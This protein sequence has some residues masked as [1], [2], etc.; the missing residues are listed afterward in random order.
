MFY[1]RIVIRLIEDC[2]GG[3]FVFLKN[4]LKIFG[5]YLIEVFEVLKRNLKNL[6]DHFFEFSFGIK[7]FK[8]K[9]IK[10]D[11]FDSHY[12]SFELLKRPGFIL[13]LHFSKLVF[14][15]HFFEISSQVD[16]RKLFKIITLHT[17]GEFFQFLVVVLIFALS[18]NV[19][20][21][22]ANTSTKSTQR[23]HLFAKRLMES[24][25]KL[26]IFLLF[27]KIV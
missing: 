27:I 23:V 14:E 16:W 20:N 2:L 6:I 17:K 10:V 22:M 11:L 1:Q 5:R 9:K 25:L 13:F 15:M 26:L 24:V 18:L 21:I 8:V 12:Q 19:P 7:F 3:F 4:N